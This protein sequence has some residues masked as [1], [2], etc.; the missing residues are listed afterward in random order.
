MHTYKQS[1]NEAVWTVGL[2]EPKEDDR[3]LFYK[4]VALK[5]FNTEEGAAAYASYLNGGSK[6]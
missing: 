3:G 5:D 4:W 1:K 6:P 2:Y